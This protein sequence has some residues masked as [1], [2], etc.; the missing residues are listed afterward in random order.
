MSGRALRKALRQRE[1]AALSQKPEDT[2]QDEEEQDDDAPPPQKPS[3]FALLDGEDEPEDEPEDED[4]EEEVAVEKPIIPKQEGASASSKKKKKKKKGKSKSAP[5]VQE[6]G[7]DEIDAALRILNLQRKNSGETPDVRVEESKRLSEILRVDPRN[8]DAANEM[9]RL[10]GRVALDGAEEHGAGGRKRAAVPARGLTGRKNTFVQAKEEWPVASSGGL[11]METVSTDGDNVTEFRFV[12]SRAYQD[13][14]KQFMMC[15]ASM[16]PNRLIQLMQ[17]N[18]YHVSTL[19]QASEI[20]AQQRDHTISGDL[21]ERALFTFG[22][23]LHSTFQSKISEG[24]ARLSFLYPENREFWLCSWRYLRNL[25]MRGT[26]RTAEEFARLLLALDPE[27]DPY[28]MRLCIDFIS[29]KARQPEHLLALVE[30]PMFR[31]LYTNLPNMAY[32]TALAYKQLNQD[33]AARE[34]LAKAMT[35]FPWVVTRL[36][37]ELNIETDIPPALWGALPP[38]GD[39]LQPLLAELYVSRSQDLWKESGA[40]RLLT[41]VAST[42]YNLPKKSLLKPQK[43]E[44]Q[45]IIEGVSLDIARHV[46]IADI[47]GVTALLPRGFTSHGSRGYDLLPPPGDIRSYSVD[48]PDT[49]PG[50]IEGHSAVGAAGLFRELLRSLFPHL[51]HAAGQQPSDQEVLAALRERGIDIEQEGLGVWMPDQEEERDGPER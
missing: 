25:Q 12:H 33:T 47:P 41:D 37:A 23:S 17:H 31:E 5:L 21:L 45:E 40:K 32:S 34:Y 19:L 43:T 38:E 8:F 24:N 1:L 36:Y 3:L 18:P 29:L 48:I 49:A 11:G 10:F 15:V 27:G 46:L 13:V 9:R 2:T 22:R 39:K 6:A 14:Q 28:Q 51:D 7:E 16:D 30:H 4:E 50:A 35:K 42:I 44:E 26:W 20:F